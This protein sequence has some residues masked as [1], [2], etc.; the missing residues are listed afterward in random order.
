MYKIKEHPDRL[1]LVTAIILLFALVFP[2][3]GN[4]DFQDKTMFSVPLS[5]MVWMIP[6]LLIAF[7]LLYLVTRKFL[8][9]MNIAR[10]HIFI[11]VSATF[12]MV[13]VLYIGLN[14][15][16]LTNDRLEF[17]GNTMQIL[18]IIFVCGQFVYLANVVLGLLRRHKVQ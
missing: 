4:I 18:F 3:F 8:Y 7:W 15:S 5:T 14:P 6:L 9:S 12:L 13:A 17:I 2:S 10:I 11:T 1:L 16:Q